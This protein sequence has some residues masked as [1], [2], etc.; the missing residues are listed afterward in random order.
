MLTLHDRQA[1]EGSHFGTVTDREV[2]AHSGSDRS[3]VDRRG[4]TLP[5]ISKTGSYK[6]EIKLH[7][8]VTG[9]GNWWLNSHP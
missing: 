1:G 4:I 6:A 7:P 8:E 5:D 2:T 3:E 9:S